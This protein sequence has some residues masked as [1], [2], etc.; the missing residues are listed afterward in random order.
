MDSYW[1]LKDPAHPEQRLPGDLTEFQDHWDASYKC[2]KHPNNCYIC[3]EDSYHKCQVCG[4]SL[5]MTP[6]KT[7]KRSCF[8]DYHNDVFFG[9]T[10]GDFKF[11]G[12]LKSHWQPPPSASRLC[13][14][15]EVNGF[16]EPVAIQAS[17]PPPEPEESETETE[18]LA[19]WLRSRSADVQHNNAD[20]DID[21]DMSSLQQERPDIE[22]LAN[23]LR[24]NSADVQHKIDMILQPPLGTAPLAHRLRSSSQEDMLLQDSI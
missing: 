8:I 3:G 16:M 10:R 13:N 9:L 2:R 18:P 24:S 19:H 21:I 14:T 17:V 20:D 1:K 11:V 22:P 5:H 23:R 12:A 4:F 15:T 6:P 7:T